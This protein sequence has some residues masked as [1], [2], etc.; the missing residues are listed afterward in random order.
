VANKLF[1]GISEPSETWDDQKKS[2]YEAEGKAWIARFIEEGT[3]LRAGRFTESSDGG[4]MA[5]FTSREA[6]EEFVAGDPFA[7]NGLVKGTEILE[8]REVVP[9]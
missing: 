8:W 3:L 4:G 1:V 6:A 7:R 5:F 2:I 9:D